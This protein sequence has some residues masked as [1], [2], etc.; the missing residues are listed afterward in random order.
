MK[1]AG[2]STHSILVVDDDPD[3]SMMLKLML[4]YKGYSVTVLSKVEETVKT[5]EGNNYSMAIIDMLLSGVS[6]IDICS[7]IRNNQSTAQCP[8]L[9]ISAHPNA[10]EICLQAGAD[11]FISKP[12]DMNDILSRIS[13]LVNKQ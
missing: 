10:K 5:L 11:D 1:P 7:R 3:I 8:V 9:M 12:F 6:G 13:H 4:E 2:S